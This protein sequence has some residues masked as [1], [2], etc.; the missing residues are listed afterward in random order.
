[1]AT[2]RDISWASMEKKIKLKFLMVITE[3]VIGV[4]VMFFLSFVVDVELKSE[5][6][7]FKKPLH[8]RI[9]ELF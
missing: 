1:M 7:S 8:V 5:E 9:S 6:Y 2:I 3:F 4:Y